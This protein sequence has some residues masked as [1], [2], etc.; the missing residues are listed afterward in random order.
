MYLLTIGVRNNLMPFNLL[1]LNIPSSSFFLLK[2]FGVSVLV[3]FGKWVVLVKLGKL[4]KAL[5]PINGSVLLLNYPK[6]DGQ[7]E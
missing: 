3:W 2:V 7:E 1:L 4:L 6:S 5:T